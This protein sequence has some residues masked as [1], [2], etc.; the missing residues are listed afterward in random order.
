MRIDLLA[1]TG[2][3]PLA[4]GPRAPAVLV[5]DSG[6]GGLTVL[7]ELR[8]ARP[9]AR[10]VYAADDAAFPYGDLSEE[11]LVAR[12]VAV[13][14]RLVAAHAPDLVV[15]ACNTATT[16]VLPALRARFAV[17]FVGTVPAIKPAA[18]ATRT[19]RISVLAT[20][21]TVRRDY[22][23]ELIDAYAGTCAVTLV[24]ATRLAA[25]AEADLAGCPVDDDVLREEIAPCF[26]GEG[27]ARTD[28][29]VLGCTH[30]PLLLAR[31]ERLA[32]WPVTWIDP[33]PAVAR[34]M[35]ALLG[36]APRGTDPEATPG[37]AVFT[38]GE[39][40]TAPLRAALAARGLG[41]VAVTAMPSPRQ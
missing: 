27:S 5:F 20:P 1:G 25:L 32:P 22:T 9:D 23:R 30:Y 11:M 7:S 2:A 26:V 3:A 40:L 24:G 14:E 37:L 33:A 15:V 31:F 36:P 13:M 16:L 28:V 29:V 12:V 4:P 6:L 8:R 19:G 34:R 38:G 17:P 21:G 39:G 18:A 35:A 41:K 10:I